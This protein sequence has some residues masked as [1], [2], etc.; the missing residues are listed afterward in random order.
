MH[1]SA[2]ISSPEENT[3]EEAPVPS[4]HQQEDDSCNSTVMDKEGVEIFDPNQIEVENEFEEPTE[5][6]NM[7]EI[8]LDPT[9]KTI[10]DVESTI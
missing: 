9:I 1:L 6:E 10:K 8:M 2:Y 5:S 3:A 7:R 4:L